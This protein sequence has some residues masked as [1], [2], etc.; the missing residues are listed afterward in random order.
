MVRESYEVYRG[1]QKPLEFMG[2]Q[3][4]YILWAAIT[5][6]GS[7][8]IFGIFF[9]IFG[10]LWGMIALFIFL[11]IGIAIILIKQK[12]GLHSRSAYRG[13]KIVTSIFK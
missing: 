4:R 13:V 12:K 3:G 9:S 11:G 10:F 2:L 7:F 6:L 8:I 5:V 1:L